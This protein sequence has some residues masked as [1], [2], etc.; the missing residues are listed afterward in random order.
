METKICTSC[1]EE[2]EVSKF[3]KNKNSKDGLKNYCKQCASEQ[4][5]RYREKH[6]DKKNKRNKEWYW[7]SK[8]K[9]EQRTSEELEKKDKVCSHCGIVKPVTDYYRR[10]N[11]GFYGEC[12]SC[13]ANKV[14]VYKDSIR[15]LYLNRKR[16]YYEKNRD[17]HLEYYKEYHK[18]NA[19]KN[20][21]RAKQWSKDNPEKH[22]ALRV[23]SSQV[24]N[25]RKRKLKADF[26]QEE[27]EKCKDYFNNECAYCGKKMTNATQDH[28][29]PLSN[30]GHYIKGNILPVCRNCNSSKMDKRF[31][32]WYSDKPFYS[33]ARVQKIH[34]YFDYL[35]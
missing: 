33:H 3:S 5:V 15:P 24:R 23:K 11:G 1:K 22:R 6:R 26:T 12:K 32:E 29:I 14:Q 2:K 21:E 30:G 35:T 25:A 28:F 17:Y 10:G 16:V 20:I 31:D 27:W 7:K 34:D 4:G 8:E 19:D 13:H 9:K 18:N